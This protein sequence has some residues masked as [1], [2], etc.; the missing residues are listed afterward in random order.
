MN[1]TA[2]NQL[3]KSLG[4][5]VWVVTAD[6][7]GQ[8]NGL[9]ATFVSPISIVPE[10][11]R[12]A[13]ALSKLHQTW[14]LVEGSGALAVHLLTADQADLAF[15]FGTQTGREVDKFQDVPTHSGITGSPLLSEAKGWLDCRVEARFDTGDRTLYIVEVV[16]GDLTADFAPLTQRQLI[17]LATPAQLQTLRS[18]LD[19]DAEQDAKA[20]RQ[21][22]ANH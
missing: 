1:L 10:I 18:Q 16:N 4:R 19:A 8:R 22:R 2:I 3:I 14:T 20:I 13:V 6:H 12:F 7:A 17:E 21:W 15:R 11:P 9:L 5:E